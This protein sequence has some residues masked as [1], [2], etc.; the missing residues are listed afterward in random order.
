MQSKSSAV[1]NH[2]IFLSSQAKEAKPVYG[3]EDTGLCFS[4]ESFPVLLQTRS[5]QCWTIAEIL[6]EE[7]PS[8]TQRTSKEGSLEEEQGPRRLLKLSSDF[9]LTVFEDHLDT[10]EVGTRIFGTRIHVEKN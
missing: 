8:C 10:I 7:V 6:H 4:L 9:L 3:I 5:R 1:F 2:R